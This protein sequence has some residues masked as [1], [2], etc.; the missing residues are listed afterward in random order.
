MTYYSYAFSNIAPIFLLCDRHDLGYTF[1]DRIGINRQNS[2]L[3]VYDQFPGGIGLAENLFFRVEDVF[4]HLK[5]IIEQ[6]ACTDG[7]PSCIGPPGENG[8]GAKKG[9]LEL[10]IRTLH[11]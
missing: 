11:R 3:I 9:I 2:G 6:C 8:M 4:F 5:D 10:I 1:D 7:C